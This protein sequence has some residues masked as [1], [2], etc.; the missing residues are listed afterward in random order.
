MTKR[1]D[2]DALGVLNRALGLTGAGSQVTE[3]MDGVVDQV[4]DIVPVVR[5]GRTQADVQGLYYPTL[6][7]TH[8]AA[9]TQS[10]QID[11]YNVGTV[12]DVPP[13]PANMPA[14]F[15][16]W[17]IGASLRIVSGTASLFSLATLSLR[18]GTNSQGFGRTHTGGLILVSQNQRL[19][20]WDA[21]ATDVTA[22]GILNELG[23]HAK[24][25]LRLPRGGGGS[26]LFFDSVSTG[27]VAVDCQMILGVFPASLGQDARV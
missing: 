21:T 20:M 8:G 25:G 15:D 3:L 9:N 18:V 27:I 24:I 26:E 23:T 11:P 4:L 10:N 19:A 14:Q 13:Y 5:R 1:M 12:F 16:I 17:L 22:Y 7:N 6:R 2:S